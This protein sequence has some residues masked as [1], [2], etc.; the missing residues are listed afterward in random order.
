MPVW[1]PVLLHVLPFVESITKLMVSLLR[2]KPT[3]RRE[4]IAQRLENA[5]VRHLV[6]KDEEKLSK[7]IKEIQEEIKAED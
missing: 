2:K 1:L 4:R 7:E 3:E 5:F 6:D